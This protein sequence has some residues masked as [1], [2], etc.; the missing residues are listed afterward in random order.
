MIVQ[1][2]S[3]DGSC[4]LTADF[5][6]LFLLLVGS[7]FTFLPRD[8]ARRRLPLLLGLSSLLVIDIDEFEIVLIISSND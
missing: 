1:S 3:F 5:E 8:E 4:F 6:K 2:I 7:F